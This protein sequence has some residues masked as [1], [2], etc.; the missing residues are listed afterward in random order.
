MK[1]YAMVML[2]A[3]GAL[4]SACQDVTTRA[5]PIGTPAVITPTLVGSTAKIVW[6][7]VPGADG[8]NVRLSSD[9]AVLRAIDLPASVT[10][11]TFED[12]VP[13]VYDVSVSARQGGSLGGSG[14]RRFGSSSGHDFGGTTVTREALVAKITAEFP[15]SLHGTAKGMKYW[16]E[17]ASG[18]GAR[19]GVP[20]SAMTC[21]TCHAYNPALTG[22]PANQPCLACH[23]MMPDQPGVV[24]YDS[25]DNTKCM[26]CH[27]RQGAEI[28]MNMP[29]VHR[30]AGMKCSDCHK[31]AELHSGA[32]ANALFD[33]LKPRC[34][35]CH[36]RGSYSSS[37]RIPTTDSH[38]RHG[39]HLSCQAC[40]MSGTLTC[41]NC[42]L[43]DD[44]NK[45]QRNAFARYTDWMFLGNWRGQV[46]PLN[47]QTV[48]YMGQTFSAWG[49][50]NGH[51]V[52]VDGR[53]CANCHASA[54]VLA[55]S[56]RVTQWNAESQKMEHLTGVIPVP[57]D[58]ATRLSFDFMSR[59]ADGTWSFLKSG[60]DAAQMLFATPL[61]REQMQKLQQA[62]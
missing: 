62:R 51:T 8:Y 2:V 12:L 42:H 50:Y 6:S 54:N 24:D 17:A 5:R 56:L 40:H 37:T 43:A 58:Y 48:E 32:G 29:D 30:A 4:L 21:G 13:K 59:N 18:F 38:W 52:V 11:T 1:S 61:S 16:Y 28:S 60:A 25:V 9:G 34:E 44:I 55:S 47:V 39:N 45:G 49:P 14:T 15:A 41:V 33:V 57:W 31:A 36:A 27:S 22:A 10:A 46:H 19:I 20:Y 7:A 53:V 3:G 26:K 23:R 35:D